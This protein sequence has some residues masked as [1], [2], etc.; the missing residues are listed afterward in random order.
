VIIAKG[1]YTFLSPNLAQLTSMNSPFGTQP[2]YRKCVCEMNPWGFIAAT[3]MN[4]ERR[5]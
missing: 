1:E 2:C 5:G 4:V 3:N